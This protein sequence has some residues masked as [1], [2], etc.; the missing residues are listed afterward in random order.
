MREKMNK[1]I[2]LAVN[3]RFALWRILADGQ[4]LERELRD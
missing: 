2:A 3:G 4:V 1:E